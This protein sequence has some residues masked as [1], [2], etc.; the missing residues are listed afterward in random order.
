MQL[1]ARLSKFFGNASVLG[2]TFFP[3]PFNSILFAAALSLSASFRIAKPSFFSIFSI[4]YFLL[5]IIFFFELSEN[6]F[7]EA[8]VFL[9]LLVILF[10]PKVAILRIVDLRVFLYVL[11]LIFCSVG[12]VYGFGFRF[13]DTLKIGGVFSIYL[14]IALALIV[15]V[16]RSMSTI[17]L[18]LFLSLMLGSRLG[19]F[20]CLFAAI[21]PLSHN[22]HFFH[23]VL[24]L[25]PILLL[26]LPTIY[27]Y[28]VSVRGLD[29]SD[30]GSIDRIQIL[31]AFYEAMRAESL[32]TVITG[33]GVGVPIP[34]ILEN[35]PVHS[36]LRRWLQYGLASEGF[37]GMSFHNEFLRVWAN[38][39]LLGVIIL[40]GQILKYIRRNPTAVMIIFGS[41]L[42][43]SVLYVLP[44]VYVFCSVCRQD[45]RT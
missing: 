33:Y 31:I 45:G 24:I 39:G 30:I 7:K 17:A 3:A 13:L 26:G 1:K 40:Y 22:K 43:N 18:S 11:A 14:S 2:G 42:A 34:N 28:S 16:D 27:Y 15:T 4:F 25:V 38:F 12:F 44:L 9:T 10:L 20:F 21:Y 36:N 19:L 32:L 23:K 41:S 6:F 35:M 5:Y 8:K 29:V 37:T